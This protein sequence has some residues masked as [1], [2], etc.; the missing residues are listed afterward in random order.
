MTLGRKILQRT[1]PLWWVAMLLLAAWF[2]GLNARHI[3]TSNIS[4]DAFQNLDIAIQIRQTG[5][6]TLH[7]PDGVVP[8]SLREP[9]PIFVVAVYLMAPIWDNT[10]MDIHTLRQGEPARMVKL[11]NLGWVFLGLVGSWLIFAELTATRWWGALAMT[12][13]HVFFFNNPYLIDTFYTELVTA[14]LLLLVSGLAMLATRRQNPWLWLGTGI[15]MGLLCLTKSAFLYI[16]LVTI[17]LLGT[18]M[19]WRRSSAYRPVLA[20]ALM[21]IGLACTVAPWMV[22]N[23]LLFDSAQISSGRSGWV[24][25]K[26]ALLN[27]MT[28][29]EFRLAFALFGPKSYQRLVAGTSLGA[30][31]D[32]AKTRSGRLARLY[33][34]R[35]EFSGS[36]I[37]AQIAGEPDRAVTLYRKTSALHVKLARELKAAGHPLPDV[38]ADRRMQAM[39]L[40]MLADHPLSHLKVSMLMFWR[41]MWSFQP[42]MDVPFVPPGEARATFIEALNAAVVMALL[43]GFGWALVRRNLK[44]LAFTA[45]PVVMMAFY[46]LL[47]QNLPRFFVPAHPFMLLAL[48]WIL[49]TV[50]VKRTSIN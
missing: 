10:S 43:G 6:F 5:T 13:T 11:H 18:V 46:T 16:A 47:S 21:T 39:A 37:E 34:G 35:S 36:D 29:E 32:D 20:T 38:E 9:L 23:Q 31:P 8:T 4:A 41:G 30:Q 45:L 7:T 17:V 42:R 3:S 27:Q 48:L 12:T 44:V 2:T 40:R 15:G 25:Y 26:R 1:Q 22:R 24:L 33:A 14:V 49:Y 50:L 19:L 28:P